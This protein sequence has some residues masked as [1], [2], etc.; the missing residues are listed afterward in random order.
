MTSGLY[1]LGSSQTSDRLAGGDM[2]A[3]SGGLLL[4]WAC[5]AAIGPAVAGRLMAATD[6]W[7]LY[8]YLPAVL[9]SVAIFTAARMVLRSDAPRG[10]RAVAVTAKGPG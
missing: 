5:G 1:G 7:V 10:E 4:V 2:V 8:A 6:P 9:A 3:A